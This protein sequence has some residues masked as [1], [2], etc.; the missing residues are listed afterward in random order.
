MSRFLFLLLICA[1]NFSSSI[2]RAQQPSYW[3]NIE[4]IHADNTD[5]PYN[6]LGTNFK[7]EFESPI[8]K[9]DLIQNNR[10]A[11]P[12]PD[13]SWHY[14]TLNESP[15]MEPLLQ[16]KFPEIQSFLIKSKDFIGRM[17]VNPQGINAIF[18]G[19]GNTYLIDQVWGMPGVHK[20][21]LKS[22]A[23]R[24]IP[25]SSFRCQAEADSWELPH[26][27]EIGNGVRTMG[28]QQSQ[29]S[30]RTYRL[31]L[32]CT[33]EYAQ[34]FGGTIPNVMASFVTAVNRLNV[35]FERE[36][37]IRLVLVANN[38]Q[39]VFLDP[40]TDPYNNSNLNQMLG[41]NQT[42]L[43]NIIGVDN[44]DIGHVFS[45]NS[46]GGIAG[47]GVVCSGSKAR[48]VTG[49][50][51]PL[52]DPFIIDYV[53]HEMGHQFGANH[54]FNNC[55]GNE[56]PGTAFEPGSGST[57]MAYA[58]LCGNN[59]IQFNS[60]DYFHAVSLDEMWR[61]TRSGFGSTCVLAVPTDNLAPEVS[62]PYAGTLHIPKSTPFELTA[63][64][65]D[66]N[67]SN[68]LTYCWEQMDSGPKVNL[69]SPAG[70]SPLFRSLSPTSNGSR[71]FP[72]RESVLNNSNN[73]RE[74]LPNYSRELNFRCTVRD[75]NPGAGGLDWKE[76]RL[77][78]T[79]NAGPF[80]VLQPLTGAV[81]TAGSFQRVEWN[82]ANTTEA[83][84]S[85]QQVHI[86]L[87][88]N[89]GL[90]WLDT[91]AKNQP[92]TGSCDVWVPVKTIANARIRV[93]AANNVFYQVNP[94]NFS[95]R[96]P[97]VPS[98][99]AEAI[100]PSG[101]QCI[102]GEV[103][104]PLKTYRFGG[105]GD[106]LRLEITNTA[107]VNGL[108]YRI[109]PEQ[110][111]PGDSA[112]LWINFQQAIDQIDFESALLARTQ[113]DTFTFPFK[114]DIQSRVQE[115]PTMEIPEDNSS[116]ISPGTPFS[117]SPVPF[118]NYYRISIDSTPKFSNPL[119]I[120]GLTSTSFSLSNPLDI[121]SLYYWKVEAFNQCGGLM[122]SV[123]NGF[124]TLN[125]QCFNY[126]KPEDVFI[127]A[128]GTPTILSEINVVENL[129]LLT[130]EVLDIKGNH[131]SFSDLNFALLSPN[132][133]EVTLLNRRCGPVS[134]TF[135]VGFSD[136]ASQAFL[137]PPSAGRVHL[138]LQSL[139]ALA[140][141]TTQGKWGM[142]V[143]DVQAGSGGRFSG[144]LLKLCTGI[145]TPSPEVIQD[146][147]VLKPN[148]SRHITASKLQLIAQNATPGSLTFRIIEL[149]EKGELYVNNRLLEVG[150][151]FKQEDIDQVRFYYSHL[152]SET[153][154]FDKFLFV[155]SNP[156]GGWTG[157]KQFD[158]RL[159]SDFQSSVFSASNETIRVKVNPNPGKNQILI[160]LS[161][162]EKGM[163]WI[164]Y[165][166]LGQPVARQEIRLGELNTS[167]VLPYLQPGM[168]IYK[169]YKDGILL[170]SGKWIKAN[171]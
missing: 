81:W 63:T 66:S 46:G 77:N 100:I 107:S 103:A 121:N 98:Y 151:I 150:D 118:T 137:C 52:G 29:V 157:K 15:V 145:A 99:S 168:Y 86:I 33:A 94:G 57:I 47:L 37:A 111:Y 130:A 165:N 122:Q 142:R 34:Y 149:P 132:G 74:V 166:M 114:L 9:N 138:P 21:Y 141:L 41:Q 153:D 140:G 123:P 67:G 93:Q 90:T 73:I 102:P 89:G 25:R 11:L 18:Y 83:P 146:T 39:I 136:F 14:F 45:T 20:V 84:V 105:F 115:N 30:L 167:V 143:K 147:L 22:E 159:D 88:T 7:L 152:G 135:N 44:Y 68:S 78:T 35:V 2:I 53:A 65:T 76:V 109:E 24:L 112:T 154:E 31:A 156:E 71:S 58:G 80:S 162:S 158:I 113:T 32:A 51:N 40:D 26:Y 27:D 101:V 155:G 95:V 69:G 70:N 17:D 36:L 72:R 64:A 54:T 131:Q 79:E 82:P 144:W 120:D 161:A 125:I 28:L 43:N 164:M 148:T 3:Q 160:T 163:N 8:F 92:N 61:Y 119:M 50:S 60:D 6:G 139:S 10:L 42:A 170:D 126:E 116:G 96:L 19:N 129:D 23:S 169:L 127:S 1:S 56:N 59:N 108:A 48:G 104:V 75:N 124:H 12:L 117:W 16:K 49:S 5:N 134:T 85:C 97:E 4:Q 91:L 13:G 110:L 62:I 133:T 171:D 55:D 106:S 38:D 128:S 87:S